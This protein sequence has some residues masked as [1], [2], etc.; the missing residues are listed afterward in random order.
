MGLLSLNGLCIEAPHSWM[1]HP[2]TNLILGRPDSRAGVMQISSAFR[3]E[4]S[5]SAD[6]RLCE[7]IANTWFG[8]GELVSAW[9]SEIASN[10]ALFGVAS[11]HDDSDLRRVWYHLHR[12]K[13]ILGMF[14]CAWDHREAPEVKLAMAEMDL[15]MR[16]ARY[17]TTV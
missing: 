14:G 11:A 10:G 12:G 5:E 15:L 6:H 7:G 3:D 16:T 1:F 8:A 13:L 4:L 17:E 2:F 9:T